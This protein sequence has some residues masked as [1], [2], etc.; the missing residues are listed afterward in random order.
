MPRVIGLK[1]SSFDPEAYRRAMDGDSTPVHTKICPWCKQKVTPIGTKHGPLWE[2]RDHRSWS[3]D[4]DMVSYETRELRK[5]FHIIFDQI[6]K[7][8][9]LTRSEAYKELARRLDAEEPQVHGQKM[10]GD[11]LRRAISMSEKMLIE[12]GSGNR[13]TPCDDRR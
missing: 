11:F 3:E 10:H 12:Y 1:N 2:C 5:T 9:H 4:E 8:G 7:G 6:W 13:S